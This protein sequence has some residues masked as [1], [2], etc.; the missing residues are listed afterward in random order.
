MPM[1]R[2]YIP[3]PDGTRPLEF[4]VSGRGGEQVKLVSVPADWDD[5]EI[6]DELEDWR[7]QYFTTSEIVRYGWNDEKDFGSRK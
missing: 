6:K 1:I 4:W 2:K 7:Q 3:P 5:D